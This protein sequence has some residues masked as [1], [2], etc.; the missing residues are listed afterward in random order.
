MSKRY[1]QAYGA[2][3]GDEAPPKPSRKRRIGREQTEAQLQ[4]QCVYWFRM[5]YPEKLL[6]SIPN[7]GKRSAHTGRNMVEMGMTA[8]APDLFVPEPNMASSG[9][10]MELKVGYNKLTES[11]EWW[12]V[13]LLDR[14]YAWFEVRSF[15]QFQEVV[16]E[17]LGAS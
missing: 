14:A 10:F 17:Y 2:L 8:G 13:Q 7:E 3:Y 11:Q 4:K 6:L 5:Q 16:D 15:E 12:R 1:L 9:L